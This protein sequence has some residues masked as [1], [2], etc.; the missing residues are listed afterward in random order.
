V[1]IDK[2]SIHVIA[3]NLATS[4]NTVCT[5]VLDLGRS[6]LI[7]DATRLDGV[8]TIGV[9]EHWWSHRGID[10]WVTIIVDLTHRP[11]R[12]LD[13]V[14]GQSA[15]VFA[16]WLNDQS[17]AFRDGIDHVAMDAFAGYKKPPPT[18]CQRPP[19]S[20][21]PSTSSRSWAPSSMRRG[22]GSRPR[23]MDVGAGL[24][25]TC[26]GPAKRLAWK[27]HLRSPKK[28][29]SQQEALLDSGQEVSPAL[30]PPV[31]QR[32]SS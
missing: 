15:E 2:M 11:A 14:P 13:I 8:S 29:Y 30:G 17:D 28:E 27:F 19:R 9:D 18:Q 31:L 25:M 1:V 20:W 23:S 6:L 21:T 16:D 12:L 7:A 32:L 24:V 5:A 22:D 4:W 10:R 26:T 3:K